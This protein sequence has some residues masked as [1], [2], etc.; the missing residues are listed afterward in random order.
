MLLKEIGVEIILSV[1]EWEMYG[2]ELTLLPNV[3]C[4]QPRKFSS[5]VTVDFPTTGMRIRL[6]FAL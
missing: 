2:K 4:M 5:R 1:N 3:V 6:R